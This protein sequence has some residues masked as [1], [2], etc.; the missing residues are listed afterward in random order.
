[1]SYLRAA[2]AANRL[3][4]LIGAHTHTYHTIT[5]QRRAYMPRVLMLRVRA[6]HDR[7]VYCR[8]ARTYNIQISV[9]RVACTRTR[10]HIRYIFFAALARPESAI[11]RGGVHAESRALTTLYFCGQFLPCSHIAESGAA[12]THTRINDVMGCDVMMTMH[13]TPRTSFC[14]GLR[15]YARLC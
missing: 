2:A 5:L 6:D 8:C 15:N 13:R 1:M 12:H 11:D 3:Q 7:A 9:S 10:I 4:A 14:V